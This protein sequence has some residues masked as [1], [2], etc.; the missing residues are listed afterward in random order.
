MALPLPTSLC[1]LTWMEYR[2]NYN[3]SDYDFDSFLSFQKA[4]M[5]HSI[6]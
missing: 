6:F 1:G 4:V 3:E 5:I 2:N